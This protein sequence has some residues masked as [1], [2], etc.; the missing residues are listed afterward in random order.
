MKRS[1]AID[2]GSYSIKLIELEENKGQVE[3]IKAAVNPISEGNVN[4]SLRDLLA[5]TKLSSKRVNVSLSGPA[6]IVRYIEMPPMKREELRSAI[7]FE[8]EKYLPFDVNDAVMDCTTLDKNVSTGASRVLLVAAKKDKINNYMSLF[9]EFGLDIDVI[10]VD[11]VAFL[12]AFQRS[13]AEKEEA[14]TYALVNMGG[15]F[16]NMNIIANGYPYFT[17]DMLWGGMDVTAKLKESRSISMEDAE[18][19]KRDPGDSKED[20]LAAVTPILEKLISEIRMSFDYFETQFGKNIERI[21]ITGGSSYLFGITEFLRDNIGLDVRPWDPLSGIGV[22]EAVLDR[23][24]KDFPGQFAVAV[25]LALRG[26]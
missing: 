23:E 3:V 22:N 26:L 12:N 9:K 2:V 18:K 20:A 19:I 11:S 13:G 7:R 25:G 4:S 6:V 17:R 24:I 5:L 10:D 16:S 1:A 21:H 15:K 14:A 8:A